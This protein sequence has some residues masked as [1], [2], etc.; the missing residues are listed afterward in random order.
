MSVERFEESSTYVI[1]NKKLKLF[2][3]IYI[4]GV[5]LTVVCAE[6][7]QE[8]F[9]FSFDKVIINEESVACTRKNMFQVM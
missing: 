7:V 2:K 3:Y 8:W 6:Y 5:V 1:S 9:E 4:S